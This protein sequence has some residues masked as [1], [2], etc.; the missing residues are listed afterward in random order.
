MKTIELSGYN[1]V[2]TGTSDPVPSVAEEF[3]DMS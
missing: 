2:L 3:T 1:S